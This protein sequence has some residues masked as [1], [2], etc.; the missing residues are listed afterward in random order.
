MTIIIIFIIIYFRCKNGLIDFLVL[1]MV[2]EIRNFAINFLKKPNVKL[3][4]KNMKER[5]NEINH[6]I[7][8][9]KHTHTY[10]F[11]CF[12]MIKVKKKKKLKFLHSSQTCIL[13]FLLKNKTKIAK[14][15]D[16]DHHR[17]ILC[18]IFSFCFLSSFFFLYTK[19]IL[20]LFC[21]AIFFN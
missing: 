10:T 3:K 14:T 5:E 16:D 12:M 13:I 6:V 4:T 1:F 19:N 20:Y 2:F 11:I 21:N 8:I 7:I 18:V 9:I 17:H 15:F